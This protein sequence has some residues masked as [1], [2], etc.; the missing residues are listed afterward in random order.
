MNKL[1]ESMLT[2]TEAQDCATLQNDIDAARAR[3]ITYLRALGKSKGLI[4]DSI[5]SLR[6]KKG[7][8]LAISAEETRT[9]SRL[10]CAVAV[11]GIEHY[12]PNEDQIAYH[13]PE[14][15]WVQGFSKLGPPRRHFCSICNH[16]LG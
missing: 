4:A 16:I 2:P 10:E 15:G 7:V 3:Q 8:K 1:F 6:T 11:E 5:D 9:F 14:C 12:S 13:C